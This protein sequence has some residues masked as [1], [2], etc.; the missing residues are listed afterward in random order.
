M[1]NPMT[2]TQL[3]RQFKKWK[4]NY[5]IR[6]GAAEHRRDP[7]HGSWG[8]VNGLGLH[9]TGDD[10]PDA[11]DE[12]LL[13]EGRSG[14]P[15]PLCTWAM[16]DDGIAIVMSGGRSNHFGGG[17]PRVLNAVVRES[18][19]DYPPKTHEHQGSAGAVDGNTH[20]YG[21]E[22]MY[23]GSHRMTD[24]AYA[25]TLLAFA[26]VCDFHG[27]SAKSAIGHKEWSDWK[28]DPGYLDMA[29]FRADLQATID[30]GPEKN[31]V[32]QKK[33]VSAEFSLGTVD[34]SNMRS[35]FRIALGLD[36]GEITK[37]V[38][39]ARIQRALNHRYSLDLTVDGLVDKETLNAWGLHEKNIGIVGRSRVPDANSL[40][41]LAT[42]F[43]IR[44]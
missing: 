26:A 11:V 16:T 42:N 32:R 35:Q 12:K 40:K 5:R 24:A 13:W 30:A 18:Y 31:P 28:P 20:F 4:V 23:S 19:G 36:K 39:V 9:H 44:E 17:D 41:L 37:H 33:D 27:W 15:G 2:T 43:K 14:L 34:F 29:E 7:S 10:A 21:Q 25:N 38:G 1:S 3:E 8:P 22:T 6:P